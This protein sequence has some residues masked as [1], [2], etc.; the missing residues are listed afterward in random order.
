MKK[1][2]LI[3]IAL[4]LAVVFGFSTVNA[5]THSRFVTGFT[6]P[7]PTQ[8]TVFIIANT[9]NFADLTV[10]G[11]LGTVVAGVSPSDTVKLLPIPAGTVVTNVTAQIY[12][13]WSTAGVTLGGVIIGD[14]SDTNGWIT[15]MDWGPTATGVSRANG[16]Y[17]L[18]T[19]AGDRGKVYS[20]ADYI[21]ATIPA[22]AWD[23]AKCTDF[24]LRIWAECAKPS[25]QYQY[26]R[27]G[28]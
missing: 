17:F 10:N 16:A 2:W 12:S 4:I 27:K 8:N 28:Y 5:K 18:T 6:S 1:N 22:S 9:L 25:T 14:S 3:L 11:A 13:A 21:T 26:K 23:Y 7:E 20:T 15:T 19:T 24:V